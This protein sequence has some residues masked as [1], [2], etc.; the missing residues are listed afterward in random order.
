M[1]NAYLRTDT[2]AL[3]Y[4]ELAVCIAQ[5]KLDQIRQSLWY[6]V[7]KYY[8]ILLPVQKKYEKNQFLQI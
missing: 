2:K 3:I 8:T 1:L 6:M 7:R 5:Y 4:T